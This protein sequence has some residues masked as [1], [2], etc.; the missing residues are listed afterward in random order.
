MVEM[1]WE[2]SVFLA[3][4][5]RDQA[6]AFCN[7]DDR[8]GVAQVGEFYSKPLAAQRNLV[9][10][11]MNWELSVFLADR[12]R[13]QEVAFCSWGDRAGAVQVG[14]FYSKPLAAQMNLVMVE[15]SWELFTTRKQEDSVCS[16]TV[17]EPVL[18]SHNDTLQQLLLVEEEENRLENGHTSSDLTELE[19]S[20]FER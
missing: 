12:L 1:N 17:Q 15:M 18:I 2:L 4:R 10:V 8:R 14:E 19:D 13:D 16:V 5:L 11:E 6:V 9:I 3:D 7:W 20:L